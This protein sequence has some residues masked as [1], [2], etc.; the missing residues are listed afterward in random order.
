[1]KLDVETASQMIA[2]FVKE[3]GIESLNIAGPR[4]SKEKRAYNYTFN[5]MYE[6]LNNY[7]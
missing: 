3:I 6:F 7:E 5:I 2:S 4:A 1:M